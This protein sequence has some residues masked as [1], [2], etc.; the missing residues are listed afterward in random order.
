MLRE[1]QIK[2]TSESQLHHL[3]LAVERYL[4]RLDPESHHGGVATRL[5]PSDEGDDHEKA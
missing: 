1:I 4:M 3:R 5:V 2:L